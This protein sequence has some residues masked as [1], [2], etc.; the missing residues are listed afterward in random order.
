MWNG[1]SWAALG[2][3]VSAESTARVS[4]LAVFDDGSG[5]ALFAAGLFDT[6]GGQPANNIAKW[7]GASWSPLAGGLDVFGPSFPNG[8]SALAVYD[9]GAGAELYA[10]GHFVL[11]GAPVSRNI[12]R[13]NG[14]SWSGVGG[15]GMSADVLALATFDD[16]NGTQLYAG[17]FFA[18]VNGVPLPRLARWNGSAW[19]AVPGSPQEAIRSF[20]LHD[21]GSGEALYVAAGS[22]A[23]GFVYHFAGA[24]LTQLS[25]LTE[26]GFGT[27]VN[28]LASFDDGV[29]GPRLYVAG[30]QSG[31]GHVSRW[32]GAHWIS[33]DAGFDPS[34]TVLSLATFDAPGGGGARLFAGGE[35]THFGTS[36]VDHLATWDGTSWS[37][38]G[39]SSSV[40]GPVFALSSF[41]AGAGDELYVGGNFSGAADTLSHGVVRWDGASWSDLAGSLVYG[42]AVHAFT[43][44]NDGGGAALYCG[45]NFLAVNGLL[46]ANKVAR[47]SGSSWSLL[48]GGIEPS[49]YPT[50]RVLADFDDGSG[51]KLYAGGAFNV[52]NGAVGNYIARWN[53]A[54]W[55]QVG[56]GLNGQVCALAAFDD[57][58][59]AKL[60]AGGFFGGG[61][62]SH[63]MR[64]NGASWSVVGG[65]TDGNVLALA[66]FDDGGGA[67]LY[68]GGR[69]ELAGSTAASNVAK[70]NG[71]SW[72]ALGTGVDE[73]V[74]ALAVFDDGRGPALYAAGRFANAGGASAQHVARWDGA[75]WEPLGSG[76]D[77]VVEAL[78]VFD[79]GTGAAL[80]V[81]GAF[82]V[83]GGKASQFLAKWG[84]VVC[85]P[86]P[87][88]T[89]GTTSSG[90][91]PSIS[92]IGTPSASASSGFTI[93]VDQVEGQKQGHIFYGVNG[94]LANPWSPLSSSY[95]CVKAPTQRTPTQNSGGTNGACDG[96]VQIDWLDYVAT[97]PGSLGVPFS[98]GT[99]VWAQLYF[100]DPPAPKTTNLS[101]GLTFVISP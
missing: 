79:D 44:W 36:G 92:G 50:V 98:A 32:D 3:G 54:S 25:T 53:G 73:A 61:F 31:F 58:S 95:L 76:V 68:A 15:A 42:G 97:H 38:I 14:T 18:D 101:D 39:D 6:A 83:A 85:P 1:S 20:A 7:D 28:A 100:R 77:D 78:H 87:Y 12:A 46:F 4:A 59:G 70:W 75:S 9:G 49:V 55:S 51:S 17:G 47:W 89:A 74:E 43:T 80:F 64:W 30:H 40:H 10:G 35:F 67:A 37:A 11:P 84:P 91:I 45:G 29:L 57:G 48:G 22:E 62:G 63:V 8:V 65:G 66:V 13:W 93:R 96:A 81:G 33:V 86:T 23:H 26:V 56:S 82:H 69:F 94:A 34:G 41:D 90:C 99:Q 21:D 71:S 16:G 5:P 52:G 72:S 24:Q 2:S 60:Y 88:C 27:G 19:S